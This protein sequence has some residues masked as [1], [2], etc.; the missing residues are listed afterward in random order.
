MKEYKPPFNIRTID[1]FGKS[2][3]LA[4]SI[5]MG[6]AIDWQREI[7]EILNDEDVI[8]LNPRRDDWDSSWTQSMDNPKFKEQVE[9]ELYGIENSTMVI[10]CFMPNTLSP[11]SLLELG[12]CLKNKNV[13][14]YCPK[15]FYRKGNID[16]TCALYRIPVFDDFEVFKEKIKLVFKKKIYES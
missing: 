5:E 6:N 10:M 16:I 3:F 12:L 13:L 4:G 1:L 14:V 7:V 2:I 8:I 15:D 9:W 11:V